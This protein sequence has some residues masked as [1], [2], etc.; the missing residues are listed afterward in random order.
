[1]LYDEKEFAKARS[2]FYRFL[3]RVYIREP[4]K[5][6]VAQ[7]LDKKFLEYLSRLPLF[8]EG[9]EIL[10]NFAETFDDKLEQYDA[11]VVEY[12]LYMS[13]PLIYLK[14]I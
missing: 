13:K 1:M 8:K 9:A 12:N 3:S 6:V 14:T 10:K 7:I 4:S 5:E 11:L 2:N